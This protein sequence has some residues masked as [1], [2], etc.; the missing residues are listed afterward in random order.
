M[1]EYRVLTR[2]PKGKEKYQTRVQASSEKEAEKKIKQLVPKEKVLSVSAVKEQ[3]VN[4][5]GKIPIGHI[6]KRER[7]R[8]FL[9]RNMYLKKEESMNAR[10]VIHYLDTITEQ[11]ETLPRGWTEDSLQRFWRSLTGDRKHKITQCIKK[12]EKNPEIDDPKAF[13]ASLARRIG[14]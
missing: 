4:N 14:Y 10:R 9:K 7:K 2:D 1:S 11:W 13:C 6:R 3:S 5:L 12:I 8:E